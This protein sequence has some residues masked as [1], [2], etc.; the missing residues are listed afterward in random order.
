VADRKNNVYKLDPAGKLLLTFSPPTTS[1][2][3]IGQIEA[4][5]TVK[6]FIFYDDR[7]Q[8]TLLDRFLT[9]LTT[10]RVTDFTEGIIRAA[11]L[12]ADDRLWLLNESDFTLSKVDI[13]Y[14]DGILKTQLNQILP[15]SS[16]DIRFMREYQNHLYI[17]DRLSGLYIFDNM[18]TYKKKL[19]LPGVAQIGFKGEEIYYLKDNQ[20]I[21][22]NIYNQQSRSMT[23]PVG[24]S[25]QQALVG[26]KYYYFFAKTGADIYSVL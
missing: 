18:G 6:T 22:L 15:K 3:H 7:Q 16:P 5:N 8:I 13:R 21:F 12:A 20:L 2:G 14:P 9:Q 17:F 1:S 11:T 4:W 10:V 26:D 24:K 23:L 25:Y 19:P